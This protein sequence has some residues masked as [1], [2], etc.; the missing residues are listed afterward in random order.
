MVN[1]FTAELTEQEA[2][3]LKGN[4]LVEGILKDK[5]INMNFPTVEDTILPM[6]TQKPAKKGD[7]QN[8]YNLYHGGFYASGAS[9]RTWIW[10]VDIGIDFDHPDL[11]VVT[12]APYATSI[13][14][15]SA[16]DCHG[17]G[18]H[19]AGIIHARGTLPKVKGFTYQRFQNYPIPSL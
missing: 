13:L 7:S 10:I 19:V 5:K 9:K 2:F 15:D 17:H 11:N 1:S 18:T 4:P 16:E 6:P 3:N 12:Q 8:W 14:D